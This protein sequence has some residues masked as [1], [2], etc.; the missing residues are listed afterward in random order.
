MVLKEDEDDRFE[1]GKLWQLSS[2]LRIY[3]DQRGDAGCFPMEDFC[4]PFFQ[5][6]QFLGACTSNVASR[7]G[8]SQYFLHFPPCLFL[9]GVSVLFCNNVPIPQPLRT[10]LPPS[11]HD[12]PLGGP[13]PK[14]PQLVAPEAAD[15]VLDPLQCNPLTAV[16]TLASSRHGKDTEHLP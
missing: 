7:Q 8:R 6:A 9:K 2:L 11:C 15:G 3:Y 13:L 14:K 4:F 16:K 10:F 1:R 12:H 5:F